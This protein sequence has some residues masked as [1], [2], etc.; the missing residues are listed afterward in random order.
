[1]LSRDLLE[2]RLHQ[3][4]NPCVRFD[5]L[6]KLLQDWLQIRL[7]LADMIDDAGKPLF[8]YAMVSWH[9]TAIPVIVSWICSHAALVRELYW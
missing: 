8:M 3:Q 4:V 6:L 7:I 5:E 9:P 1:M 2:H